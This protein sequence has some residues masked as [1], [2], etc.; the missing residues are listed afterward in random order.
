M[1]FTIATG[2]SFS[3]GIIGD[4]LRLH[5][6]YSFTNLSNLY[7]LVIT[8]LS[9]YQ[10]NRKE[11]ISSIL[12]RGRILGL[13]IIL[14]TGIVY[15]F[16]LLPERMHENP[17]YQLSIGNIITHYV[18]PVLMLLDWIIFDNKGKMKKADPAIII[19]F[20]LI[21][22]ILFSLYGYFGLQIPN[23]KSSYIYF[24]MDFHL[25]GVLGVV[26]WCILIILCLIILVYGIF[27]L[28][29]YLGNRKYKEGR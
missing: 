26:R 11:N 20:P 8:V 10:L 16:I 4:K 13:I 29:S 28:D 2:V 27:F 6:L 22:F 9:I 12:Y 23:R 19:S 25:L 7:I 24:F 21:Y 14:L 17:N 1:A 18:A 15:H 3:V 5:M